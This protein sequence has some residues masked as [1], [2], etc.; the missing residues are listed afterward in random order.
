MTGAVRLD[1]RRRGMLADMG[2]DVWVLRGELAAAVE[3]TQ[4]QAIVVSESVSPAEPMVLEQAPDAARVIDSA[5]GATER[6][7]ASA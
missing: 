1:P 2:I 6:V 7:T 3:D 4:I 5:P